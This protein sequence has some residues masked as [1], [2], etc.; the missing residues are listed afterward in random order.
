MNQQEAP[1][2]PVEAVTESASM[3]DFALSSIR[4][5]MES[6]CTSWGIVGPLTE[7]Q[8]AFGGDGLSVPNDGENTTLATPVKK[9][10][11]KRS[12]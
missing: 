12:R 5:A 9:I 10:S 4:S 7:A 1:S 8:P 2:L 3:G 11:T 6:C